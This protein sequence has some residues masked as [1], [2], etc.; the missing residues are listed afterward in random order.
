MK[1]APLL[2]AT[3]TTPTLTLMLGFQNGSWDLGFQ[4]AVGGLN[5]EF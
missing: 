3:P 2:T 1:A 4:T 5:F